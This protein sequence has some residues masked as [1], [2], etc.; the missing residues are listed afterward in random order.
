MSPLSPRAGSPF[1][2]ERFA[3][4][5]G[6]AVLLSPDRSLP[7]VS[8]QLHVL[9][10]SRNER[11]GITGISHLFEH[12]MFNGAAKYGRKQFDRTLE[13]EGGSSNASTSWDA[14]IYHEE[15]PPAAL[16]TVIDLEADRL[17]SLSIT[18]ESLRSEGGVVR[19]ERRVSVENDP[20][21]DL[22]ERLYAVAFDAH[23]YGAPIVGWMSD[24][25]AMTVEDLRAYF[26]T[27]YAPGNALLVVAGDFDPADARDAIRSSFE[28]IPPGTPPPTVRTVEP[29][30]KGEK[31]FTLHREAEVPAVAIAFH[32]P[33]AADASDPFLLDLA[34]RILAGGESGRLVRRL[35]RLEESALAV[36]FETPWTI[37]PGLAFA[38]AKVAP[39]ADPARVEAA[40]LEELD[41][42]ASEEIP[43]EEFERARSALVSESLRHLR[44][45]RGRAEAIGQAETLFGDGALAFSLPARYRALEPGPVRELAGRIFRASNRTVATL[46]PSGS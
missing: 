12:M 25:E 27:Y 46:L 9:A 30:Q 42:L 18:E 35:L 17:R 7:L 45:V 2:L 28:D 44:T 8:F 6:L 22:F 36:H 21:G 37:D 11:P 41:R 1:P 10:G 5:N 14:T 31:R 26:A 33:R 43:A 13:R 29:A 39:P 23:P 20:D 16:R 15:F 19:E 34:G 32:G 3:L 4:G 40:I 24:L 38:F